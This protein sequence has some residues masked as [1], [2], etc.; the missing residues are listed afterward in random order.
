MPDHHDSGL[1]RLAKFAGLVL[2]LVD[3][4]GVMEFVEA[5]VADELAAAQVLGDDETL[6]AS[7]RA[8]LLS[9]PIPE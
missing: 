8:D 1:H 2:A 7:S 6:A 9:C 5:T 3:L 4:A